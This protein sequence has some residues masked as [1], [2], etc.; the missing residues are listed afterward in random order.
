MLHQSEDMVRLFEQNTLEV[1][2][3]IDR[4]LLLLRKSYEEDPKHFDLRSWATRTAALIDETFQIT[5][6]G[7]SG[8]QLASTTTDDLGPPL[9]LGDREYFRKQQLGLS[10][11]KLFIIQPALSRASTRLSLQFS[12]R[13]RAPDGGFGGVIVASIDPNFIGRFFRTMPA[14]K[15]EIAKR[16]A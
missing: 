16:R 11:D 6:I 8:F 13:L 10:T 5:L 7:A 1:L 14:R 4:T 9:Y 15:R 2:E 12:S 3:R